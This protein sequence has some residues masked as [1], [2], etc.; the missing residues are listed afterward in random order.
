[1]EMTV[2]YRVKR[3]FRVEFDS[4]GNLLLFLLI[5][6]YLK[7]PPEN[8]ILLEQ[9]HSISTSVTHDCL[10]IASSI[11]YQHITFDCGYEVKVKD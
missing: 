11:K 10:T 8:K 6:L 3:D 2:V 7:T 4:L 9:H 5:V 1:M